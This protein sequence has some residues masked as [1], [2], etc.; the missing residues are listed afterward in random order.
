MKD[1]VD[2]DFEEKKNLLDE[3]EK[4]DRFVGAYAI[5]QHPYRKLLSMSRLFLSIF[6][7]LVV[8]LITIAA[9]FRLSNQ[10][11]L[12]DTD[13]SPNSSNSRTLALSS[14]N[15]YG[16]VTMNMFQYPFL[17]DALLMEPYREGNITIHD[18]SPSCAYAYVFKGPINRKNIDSETLSGALNEILIQSS[19]KRFFILD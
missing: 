1:N 14:M 4:K 12:N 2:L 11:H 18:A 13:D 6:L 17:N 15:V 19:C 16:N 9:Y 3:S 5:P 7:L 10:R 8:L